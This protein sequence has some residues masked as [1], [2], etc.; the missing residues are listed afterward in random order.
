M[1]TQKLQG[2][3]STHL[4]GTKRESSTQIETR[5]IKR[6]CIEQKQK[7][8]VQN[9]AQQGIK[10]ES[11]TQIETRPVKRVCIEKRDRKGI[12]GVIEMQRDFCFN[13]M[14]EMV[15]HQKKDAMNLSYYKLC[16][17]H[18]ARVY[19]SCDELLSHFLKISDTDI[20]TVLNLCMP[21]LVNGL[22]INLLNRFS[23]R[24]V[25]IH[26]KWT[27]DVIAN[28]K[29]FQESYYE[30]LTEETKDKEGLLNLGMFYLDN[31]EALLAVSSFQKACEL[32]EEGTDDYFNCY[33]Q[34]SDMLQKYMRDYRSTYSKEPHADL[35]EFFRDVEWILE[36]STIEDINATQEHCSQENYSQD[37][38]SQEILSQ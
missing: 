18:M 9:S 26:P 11:N 14:K 23:D 22:K 27:N 36:E 2:Q 5:P 17:D 4:K 16:I 30:F 25:N 8:E 31:N 37:Y 7:V 3:N 6:V 32:F 12:A 21:L 35:M 20:R 10:R 29:K 24:I 34:I 15:I 19:V 13:K 33:R 28:F 1:N 38:L